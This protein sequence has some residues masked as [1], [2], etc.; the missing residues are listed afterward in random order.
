MLELCWNWRVYESFSWRTHA[1]VEV[2]PW[3]VLS[4][5]FVSWKPSTSPMLCNNKFIQRGED[6]FVIKGS[7]L[8]IAN[9]ISFP[10]EVSLNTTLKCQPFEFSVGRN[11]IKT[12]SY[13]SFI[14]T[15]KYENFNSSAKLKLKSVRADACFRVKEI[16]RWQLKRN[17][18]SSLT[19]KS[20][21]SQAT[22]FGQR[23][24]S[25]F[26]NFSIIGIFAQEGNYFYKCEWLFWHVR[27]WLS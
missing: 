10:Y 1:K 23:R 8:I 12:V 7:S 2:K 20:Y 17:E 21:S 15:F 27:T 11:Q 24:V 3:A 9:E 6:H 16:R 5:P 18:I 22:N 14:I 4:L 13:E 19:N 25:F 26:L